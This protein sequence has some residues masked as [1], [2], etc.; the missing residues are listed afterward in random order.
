M[1]GH[2]PAEDIP[3]HQ[4]TDPAATA[5][6][7]ADYQH[8]HLT[9]ESLSN[10]EYECASPDDISLPPLSET[11]ESNLVPSENDL[12][13]GYCFSSHSHHVNQHSHQSHSHSQQHGDTFH[14]H[15]QRHQEWVSSQ[16]ESY[17][18]PTGGLGVAKF[19]S[20]SSSFVRS[21][22]TVPTPNLVSSTISTILKSKPSPPPNLHPTD[23]TTFGHHQ[24]QTVHSV[25][26]SRVM[27]KESVH[28]PRSGRG[29]APRTSN[30]HAPPS[31][32]TSEQDPDV[33]KPMAIREEIRLPS[34]G[35][36]VVGGILAGQG[37]NFS[38][39]LSNATVMEGSPV[40]LEV[41][42]TGFP[43]PTLTWW[44]AYNKLEPS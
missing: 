15:Y 22:L 4:S 31:L 39:H 35:R 27:T 38:K 42:V 12:E 6:S 30:T 40:T 8:D 20:E 41:E 7:E 33:C 5:T 11:P 18:S 28:E 32:L 37:P 3:L 14:H 25:H 1:G 9:E 26:E 19:R 2:P 10:D 24:Q 21:P 17:P 29:A 34:Y 16:T 44:V 36:A 43:E 23:A 13:D